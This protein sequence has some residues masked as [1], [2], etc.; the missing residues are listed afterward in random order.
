MILAVAV[1][2]FCVT[3]AFAEN[4][5]A[6]APVVF[7]VGLCTHFAHRKGLIDENLKLIQQSGAT[8][9]RDELYWAD[10]EKEKGVFSIPK[11]MEAWDAEL[12]HAAEMGIPPLI[13]LCY[14]NPNYDK[15]GYP[16]SDEALEGYAKYCEFIVSHFKG[17]VKFYEVWNEWDGG[18]GMH[19]IPGTAEGYAKLLKKVY[20]RIKKADPEATVLGGGLAGDGLNGWLDKIAKF[21]IF[22]SMDG[23]SIHPYSYVRPGEAH[24]P[25]AMIERPKKVQEVISKYTGGRIVPIYATETGYPNTT[26]QRG[27]TPEETAQ[28]LARSYLLARTIP[29]FKG[30]WWYDFQDDG[31]HFDD[32]ESNFGIVRPDLTPKSAYY[33]LQSIASLISKATYVGRVE[34][35]DPQIYVLKFLDSEQKDAWAIWSAHDDDYWQV[36]LRN[37]AEKPTSVTLQEVGRQPIVRDW[38]TRDWVSERSASPVSTDLPISVRGMPWLVRGNLKSVSV[39]DVKHFA[40]PEKDRPGSVRLNLPTMGFALPAAGAGMKKAFPV[41][42]DGGSDWQSFGTNA[43]YTRVSGTWGGTTDLDARFAVKYDSQTLYIK[44][45]VHDDLFDQTSPDNELWKGD[46]VQIALQELPKNTR[47]IPAEFTELSIA[48]SN[49]IPV[50]YREFAQ[51]GLPACKIGSVAAAIQRTGNTTLYELA[52]PVKSVD[53]P[54]LAPG[55]VIAMSMVVNDSDAGVRKGFL[56]WG[57]GVGQGKDPNRFRWLVMA[58]Q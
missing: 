30:M 29:W 38:G 47:K 55:T 34:T 7:Q 54:E 56:H 48:L 10:V 46:S 50:V 9:I 32:N 11:G 15:G 39:I 16:L 1:L 4:D 20:P 8:A 19:E 6:S 49:K 26:S 33:A 40:F 3:P 5:G 17:K 57:D 18:C 12:Q 22:G 24:F 41:F 44:I 21:D 25:E 36:M 35:T 45:I 27:S 37:T 2:S 28:F 51:S 23:F 53:L 58:P 52:I 13:I 42:A 43:N 31:I 14:A